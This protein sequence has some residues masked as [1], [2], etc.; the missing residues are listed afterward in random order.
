M[1]TNKYIKIF[2]LL[3]ILIYFFLGM[4]LVTSAA[5]QTCG[6][7]Y[8]D[9]GKCVAACS[10]GFS[11]DTTAGLCSGA[12][13]CCH[14]YGATASLKLQI[15]LL[16]YTDANSIYEY[17]GNIYTVALYIIIPIAIVVI[18]FAGIQWASSAGNPERIK[19]SK[20]LLF[21]AFLGI[22]MA[23]FSY[24]ILSVV[25]ITQLSP[26]Q[27]KYIS[28]ILLEEIDNETPLSD[29]CVPENTSP[30]C[31]SGVAKNNPLLS[32]AQAARNCKLV[33]TKCSTCANVPELKQNCPNK[34][35]KLSYGGCGTLSSSGCGISSLTMVLKYL[36]KNVTVENIITLADQNDYR[37]C[38]YTKAIYDAKKKRCN[39]DRCTGTKY[40]IFTNPAQKA[41]TT[42]QGNKT[43][44]PSNVLKKY[45]LNGEILV[46]QVDSK[47]KD[48]DSKK[49][50]L[51]H[52][53]KGHPIIISTDN[54]KVTKAG[55]FI[56]LIGCTDCF[57]DKKRKVYYRD[58]N[59]PSG[60]PFTPNNK[61]YRELFDTIKSAFWIYSGGVGSSCSASNPCQSDYFCN[62]SGACMAK[63]PANQI[64]TRN[65]MCITGKCDLSI[66]KCK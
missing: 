54:H 45:G 49:E 42:T 4:P 6:G 50:I 17:I 59:R 2:L 15:P 25:G 37:N 28:P 3:F 18:I 20:A 26:L 48:V 31:T 13:K 43:F 46:G 9:D 58:P 5:E 8:P 12:M 30:E 61:N 35:R 39:T 63:R 52:L 34:N 24:V 7:K 16:T 47:G 36:G 53:E 27:I 19:E 29:R 65:E 40:D 60:T 57:N 55:H 14:E 21:R 44:G 22:G 23:L 11:E 66:S 56:V 41:K 32:T 1:K 38:P 62:R 51:K 33:T 64:C 10:D